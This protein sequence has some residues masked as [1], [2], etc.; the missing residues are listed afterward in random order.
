MNDAALLAELEPYVEHLTTRHLAATKEWFPH[1]L[2]PLARG[3]DAEPGRAWVEADADLGG[4]HID[5]AVRSAL[6]VNLLTEDNLPYYFRTIEHVFGADGP[7]GTWVRRWTAEEGRHSMAIY[8]YLIATRAVDPVDLERGRMAQVSSGQTPDPATAADGMV[9]VALQEV[10]TRITHYNTGRLIGDAVGFTMLKRVAAD[11]NLHFLFYRDLAS[12]A[13]EI[14]P[15]MMVKAIE[16]QVRE[17]E[18][19]GAGI[20]GFAKHAAAIARAGI[21]DL[22]IHHDQI[23]APV[24]LRDW[25]VERLTGLDTEAEQA[26]DRLMARLAK[27]KRVAGRVVERRELNNARSTER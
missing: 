17:F 16:R 3:R 22:A 10:A 23:L 24:V 27:S 25:G 15:S 20:P 26:R 19:P 11:E 8:G 1:E 18:M 7:F 2:I 9:Y 21:Y 14:D 12:K 13:I 4:A 6:V 5:D